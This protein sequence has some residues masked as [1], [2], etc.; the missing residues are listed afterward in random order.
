MSAKYRVGPCY[1]HSSC[2]VCHAPICTDCDI[3]E[4]CPLHDQEAAA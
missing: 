2:E 1:A 3:P 4:N